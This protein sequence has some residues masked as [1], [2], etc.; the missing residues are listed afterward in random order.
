MADE[1][2]KPT[3]RKKSGWINLLVDYGPVIIF[4]IAYRMYRPADPDNMVGEVL[5]VTR[6]TGIFIVATIAAL[7]ISHFK[8]GKISP[9]LWLTTVLVVGFGA[10][11]ILTQDP[12]WIRHKPTGIYL[13][14]AVLL[15]G[16]WLRGKAMLRILLE[17][18]FDGLSEAG[19]MKL[20]RNWGFFFLFLAGLNEVFASPEWFSFDE[21]LK[22][23]LV[24]FMPLSFLFTFAHMPML[25][26]HGLGA[27]DVE[28]PGQ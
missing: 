26:K 4:F 14:F 24:V 11:T 7:A 13:L 18:A 21:W 16:G 9:M 2:S 6:S 28:P 8:L 15:L 1:Q 25:M 10:L 23:K 5:A 12:F 3:P 27:S 22:A 19:W 20:S 17:S